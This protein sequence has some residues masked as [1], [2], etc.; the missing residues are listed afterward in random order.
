MAYLRVIGDP[1]E[2]VELR[3]GMVSEADEALRRAA[4]RSRRRVHLEV[5]LERVQRELGYE[6]ATEYHDL[7]PWVSVLSM[8]YC[9]GS[10]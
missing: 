9:L 10:V 3:V 8:P 5:A 4:E 7:F 2:P 6:I 1:G